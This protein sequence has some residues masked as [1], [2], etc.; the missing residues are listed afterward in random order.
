MHDPIRDAKRQLR[1]GRRPVD[2]GAS[3]L[4]VP[5]FRSVKRCC[6]DARVLPSRQGRGSGCTVRG[7]RDTSNG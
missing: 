4:G 1:A 5:A 3:W 2:F 7:G 6:A